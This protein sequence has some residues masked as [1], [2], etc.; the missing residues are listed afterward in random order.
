MYMKAVDVLL[1]ND[2]DKISFVHDSRN[3]MYGRMTKQKDLTNNSKNAIQP[4][5]YSARAPRIVE[6]QTVP[7]TAHGNVSHDFGRRLRTARAVEKSPYFHRA[8]QLHE[9]NIN[10]ANDNNGR[11][12]RNQQRGVVFGGFAQNQLS[13]SRCGHVSC[14]S[15]IEKNGAQSNIGNAP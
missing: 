4:Y 9:G 12:L 6:G 3:H 13:Q 10:S 1:R 15:E 7:S 8:A 5:L 14:K 11:L 2:C